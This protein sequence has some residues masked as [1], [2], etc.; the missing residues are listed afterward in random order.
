MSIKSQLFKPTVSG[1]VFL[2]ALTTTSFAESLDSWVSKS[3]EN[4]PEVLQAKAQQEK[5]KGGMWEARSY[6]LPKLTLGVSAVRTDDALQGFGMKVM[7]RQAS[8]NDFGIGDFRLDPTS[9]PEAQAQ[10]LAVQPDGLNKPD[11][12]QDYGL[13]AQV[14]MPLFTGGML[15]QGRKMAKAGVEATHHA[16]NLA[17]QKAIFTVLKSFA[18]ING[19]R[20]YVKVASQAETTY[21]SLVTMIEHMEKEGLV[22]KADLLS[23]KLKLNDAKLLKQEALDQ[24]IA[25]LEQLKISTGQQV[26]SELTVENTELSWKQVENPVEWCKES[27]SSN[28]GIKAFKSQG[29]MKDA[30]ASM[31]NATWWP[32]VG[33]MG[34]LEAHNPDY[35]TTDNWSYT[36]GIQAKWNVFEGGKTL[37]KTAQ[38]KA[39]YSI[40]K[41]QFNKAQGDLEAQCLST[42]RT[43]TRLNQ[44]VSAKQLGVEQAQ[45]A[46]RIIDHRYK[47]GLSPLVEWFGVQTQVEKANADL[48]AAQIE[49]NMQSAANFLMA[50]KLSKTNWKSNLK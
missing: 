6:A 2:S 39:D 28:P 29:D 24:E 11:D 43:I 31:A 8:F 1:L 42:Q 50:G 21:T 20:A 25:S 12:T 19:A 33:A 17:D 10:A 46:F 45:E 40:W 4:N 38:A 44:K 16:K 32:E 26:N 9:S 15:Y 48:I 14:E 47:E 27:S 3:L 7:Q 22:S 35:P 37:G 13:S 18:E 5:A 23:A 30:E 41:A 36:V 34:K 49:L